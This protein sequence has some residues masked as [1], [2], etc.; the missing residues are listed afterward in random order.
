MNEKISELEK[1]IRG[2][3]C[4]NGHEHEISCICTSESCK[5]KFLCMHCILFDINHFNDHKEKIIEVGSLLAKIS[6]NNNAK[7]LNQQG[8]LLSQICDDKIQVKLQQ[9]VDE[10]RCDWI[11]YIDNS[12]A[13]IGEYYNSWKEELINFVDISEK[14][15][16]EFVEKDKNNLQ[17]ELDYYEKELENYLKN[18]KDF[19]MKKNNYNDLI[20]CQNLFTDSQ[21]QSQKDQ[22]Q[23]Q[24]QHID[25]SNSQKNDNNHD[26][27]WNKQI[28]LSNIDN[29]NKDKINELSEKFNTWRNNHYDKERLEIIKKM[30]DK[31]S[32]CYTEDKKL[33]DNICNI[34]KNKNDQHTFIIKE[35]DHIL[36]DNNYTN[37]NKSI[38]SAL[39]FSNDSI[40]NEIFLTKRNPVL[41]TIFNQNTTTTISNNN[42]NGN[43]LNTSTNIC[44]LQTIKLNKKKIIPTQTNS[45]N[46]FLLQ[47]ESGNNENS[48]FCIKD[49]SQQQNNSKLI[50]LK[51][52]IDINGLSSRE[53]SI[54]SMKEGNNNQ[55]LNKRESLLLA[56]KHDLP[57]FKKKLKI[58]ANNSQSKISKK[59]HFR[60]STIHSFFQTAPS[61]DDASNSFKQKR[62]KDNLDESSLSSF[63]DF[64]SSTSNSNKEN[65]NEFANKGTKLE[66]KKIS[67]F[68]Y[69]V[70]STGFGIMTKSDQFETMTDFNM[71]RSVNNGSSDGLNFKKLQRGYNC[72][73]LTG[74]S[75]NDYFLIDLHVEVK[76]RKLILR[77]PKYTPDSVLNCEKLNKAELEI[78][79]SSQHKWIKIAII[80]TQGN[81]DEQDIVIL[82]GQKIRY[83]KIVHGTSISTTVPLGLGKL[84]V[85]V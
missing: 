81:K 50:A 38:P 21:Q 19:L 39:N 61:D 41:T 32:D 35:L 11:R 46:N 75:P 33:F 70:K 63:S 6:K 66:E 2:Q 56:E 62:I 72:W 10:V 15:M 45:S 67:A 16:Y 51:R 52:S 23:Q 18:K 73:I 80:H 9:N 20:D 78:F 84:S 27:I 64:D 8:E 42:A 74:W 25:N 53:G 85:I 40:R 59:R 43:T 7:S 79:D 60:N 24:E 48:L 37:N 14:K 69:G 47:M 36:S 34:F 29:F 3:T 82:I 55:V 71:K 54:E 1:K 58:D 13:S 28:S 76:V 68:D 5:N 77:P 22:E 30:R 49:N 65:M 83:F 12:Y 17:S 31:L 26:Q 57:H 44:G 4:V